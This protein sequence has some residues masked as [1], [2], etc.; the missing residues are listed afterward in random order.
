MEDHCNNFVSSEENSAVSQTCFQED[1]D[2]CHQLMLNEEHQHYGEKT[3]DFYFQ[4]ECLPTEN[5]SQVPHTQFLIEK[6]NNKRSYH[7]QRS[8]YQ[9]NVQEKKVA[10]ILFHEFY[11]PV[12]EYMENFVDQQQAFMQGYVQSFVY[13]K[14]SWYILV[15]IFKFQQNEGIKSNKQMLDWFHQKVE[16]T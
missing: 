11:D 9:Q 15:L 10:K 14:F 16:F 2:F 3:L 1:E 6:S 8:L 7:V 13:E 12:A 4:P 5:G